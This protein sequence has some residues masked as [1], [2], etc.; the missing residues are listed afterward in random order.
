LAFDGRGEEMRGKIVKKLVLLLLLFAGV[1]QASDPSPRMTFLY[2][3]SHDMSR[4]G[5]SFKFYHDNVTGNEVAC[6]Q[7]S[8][9]SVSC[10][11]TGR[12]WK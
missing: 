8:S 12:N 5:G 2:E 3:E 9:Y 10:Y 6:V 1:V 11:L 4:W 7:A